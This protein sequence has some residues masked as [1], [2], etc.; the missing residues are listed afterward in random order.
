MRE[1]RRLFKRRIEAVRIRDVVI[2]PAGRLRHA[3]NARPVGCRDA[4]A[5][6]LGSRRPATFFAR[7]L[8]TA[9]VSC[10]QLSAPSPTTTIC[11]G[12]VLPMR[13]HR[14]LQRRG[15]RARPSRVEL[16]QRPKD[17]F[18]RTVGRRDQLDV[19]AVAAAA[20][21]ERH[22]ADVRRRRHLQ[23]RRELLAHDIDLG[24][25]VR[26]QARPH[27]A[28]AVDHEHRRRRILGARG[29][30]RPR[31]ADDSRKNCGDMQKFQAHR[32]LTPPSPIP[33]VTGHR[34]R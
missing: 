8:T 9:Q 33:I 25:I 19:V 28:R 11:A 26:R 34:L 16:R 5:D 32:P 24:A 13:V 7:S 30:D 31:D 3:G 29:A 15:D 21:S 10:W 17:V 22:E 20:M 4:D 1:L 23:K 2:V 27:R 6:V 14:D 12:R 18:T